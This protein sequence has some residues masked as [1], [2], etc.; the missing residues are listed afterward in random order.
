[1]YHT[2]IDEDKVQ[3]FVELY[4]TPEKVKQHGDQKALYYKDIPESIMEKRG[5]GWFILQLET[6]IRGGSEAF[7]K[8]G[9]M[10]N[11]L[12]DFDFEVEE[13]S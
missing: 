7:L 3:A 11:L 9:E 10:F 12:P 8:A 13:D 2:L 4:G 1:M 6:R 5:G